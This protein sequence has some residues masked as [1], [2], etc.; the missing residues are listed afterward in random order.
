[1][2]WTGFL[3]RKI[4]FLA[5]WISEILCGL[6]FQICFSQSASVGLKPSDVIQKPAQKRLKCFWY[7]SK[8]MGKKFNENLKNKFRLFREFLCV[9]PSYRRIGYC[10]NYKLCGAPLCFRATLARAS[11]IS[12]TSVSSFRSL[13]SSQLFRD[14]IVL[15]CFSCVL[16]FLQKFVNA[17][18]RSFKNLIR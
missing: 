9:V 5:F 4:S 17:L 12:Q 14:T 15:R 8:A 3:L 2:E 11:F 13:H 7:V 6:F 1:M 18:R 10:L 16:A